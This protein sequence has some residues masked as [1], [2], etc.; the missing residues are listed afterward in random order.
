MVTLGD[1]RSELWD[2]TSQPTRLVDLGLRLGGEAFVPGAARVAVRYLSGDAY[3][4]DPDWLRA[5]HG[6]AATLTSAE[7]ATIACSGPL[8]Q[9]ALP[10]E[11]L[12]TYIHDD[13]PRAC[14]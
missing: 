12:R 2:T 1:G 13:R 14:Q 6:D 10:I 7:L 8:A 5:M 4:V 3:L 9:V 11:E